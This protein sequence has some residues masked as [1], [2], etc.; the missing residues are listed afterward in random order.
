MNFTLIVKLS[1]N[2]LLTAGNLTAASQE[3]FCPIEL[4]LLILLWNLKAHHWTLT[5]AR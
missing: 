2:A 5:W 1:N 3:E 4:V